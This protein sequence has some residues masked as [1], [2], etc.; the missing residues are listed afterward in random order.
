MKKRKIKIHPDLAKFFGG[1]D[2]L[3]ITEGIKPKK[4]G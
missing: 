1:K 2:T 4:K 3:T